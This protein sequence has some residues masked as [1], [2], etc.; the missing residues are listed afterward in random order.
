MTEEDMSDMFVVALRGARWAVGMS[1]C[2]FKREVCRTFSV[3]KPAVMQAWSLPLGAVLKRV[4][5]GIWW[6]PWH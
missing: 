3:G 2:V 5:K 6:M 4:M 1:E